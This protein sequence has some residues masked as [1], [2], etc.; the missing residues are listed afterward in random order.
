MVLVSQA[1]P[2]SLRLRLAHSSAN[3]SQLL[4]YVGDC[5]LSQHVPQC[6]RF[7]V[8]VTCKLHSSTAAAAG[9]KS[10]EYDGATV[11]L[12]DFPDVPL[13]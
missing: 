10:R 4:D 7:I 5:G 3:H 13:D 6:L 1:L 2:L 8:L 9:D 11:E 12:Q